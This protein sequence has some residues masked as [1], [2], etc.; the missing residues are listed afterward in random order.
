MAIDL[1]FDTMEQ[2]TPQLRA[3]D[4]IG[5]E[6]G[7]IDAL[8]KLPESPFHIVAKLAISNDPSDAARHFDAFYKAESERFEVKAVYTEM[9]GFDINAN[10]WFC[11]LFAFAEDGGLEDVDW[12]CEWQSESFDDYTILGLEEL[13]E[14]YDSEAFRDPSNRDAS[15]LC[16]I[17][18][19]TKF[20]RFMQRAVAQMT[21][22]RSPLYLSLIHI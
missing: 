16:S 12:L 10:R 15:Y 21:E 6:S 20:Q 8:L 7:A 9:N 22:L 14:V 19:V 11:D 3:G 2:L 5:C 13:Q 1:F 17:V 18:V 4:L